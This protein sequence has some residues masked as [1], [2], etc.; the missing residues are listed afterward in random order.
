MVIASRF[1][2]EMV[3]HARGEFPNEACGLL[4]IEDGRVVEFHPTR[5]VAQS[6]VFFEIDSGELLRLT[7][8]IEDRGLGLGIYHSHTHTPARP[9]QTDIRL[10]QYPDALYLILSLAEPDSPDLKAFRI[11]DG[12]TDEVP[13]EVSGQ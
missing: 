7:L 6:P 13:V 5:N 11:V 1:V 2:E 10:A 3:R 8:D 9:S 12:V 4:A